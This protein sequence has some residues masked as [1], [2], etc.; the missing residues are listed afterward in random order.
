MNYKKKSIKQIKYYHLVEE[1]GKGASAKVYLA[2]DD[3]KDELVAVKAIPMESLKKDRGMINLQREVKNLNKLK[4][5]NIVR[6]KGF[7]NTKN[8]N[9]V[10]IE[11]CNGGNLFD[12]KKFYEKTTKTTLNEFFIQ[13]II[14]QIADG[15][16][17]MHSKNVVHRDIKLE[18]I[19]IN[20]NK[21]PNYAIK[22]NL[23]K[24]VKLDEVTLNDSFT[25]KIADLGYSKDL[26]SSSLGSTILGTPLNM[27]PDIV[28]NYMAKEGDSKYNTSVDLWSLGTI[29]YQLLTG[30]PPFVGKNYK[31]IFKLIMEGKY[32]LPT[33]LVAS[34]EIITFINGLLQ[35]YPNKRLTWSQIKTH[36]FITKSTDSFTYIQLNSLKESDKK[37]IEMNSKDCDN[38]LWIL[39]KGKGLN[40]NIDK[41]NIQDLKKDQMKQSLS[42]NTVNNDEIKKAIEAEKK[43]IEEEK[44]RLLT[45]KNEAEKLKKEAEDLKKEANLIQEKNEQEKAKLNEEEKKRKELEEKLKKDGVINELKEKEIKKQ[46]DEYTNKIKEV[47]KTKKE[48]DQKLKDAEKLLKNAEK[49]Q[50]EAEN[51]MNNLNKQKEIEENNRK[52]EEEKFKLKQKELLEEKDKFEKEIEKIKDEQ[53][54]KEETYAEE[55]N[56]LNKQIEEMSKVKEDLEKEVDK[57]KEVQ[58]ELQKKEY[59]IKEYQDKLKKITEEKDKEIEK[60]E[61]EKKQ[62][63]M[64]Q[65]K[66]KFNAENLKLNLLEEESKEKNDDKNDFDLDNNN[67]KINDN[68]NSANNKE[69]NIEDEYSDWV[70]YKEEQAESIVNDV[71]YQKDLLD[72]YEIIENYDENDQKIAT[73]KKIE[74]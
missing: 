4:H 65:E 12:Y 48:N 70:F 5:E 61:S 27:S 7:E 54:K 20:F 29:T 24:K 55:K 47:E 60:C 13:K 19:L 32:K 51:Q 33:T 46:I 17:F 63:E 73:S 25:L 2:V 43:K 6:I 68:D 66:V 21:F 8:N 34:I 28:S 26:E 52:M 62:L 53:K 22:G 1:I 57:N 72:E 23:P 71:D 44:Q 74:V 3:R 67:L 58:N 64:L 56:K 16:E 50:K 42:E 38:L 41:I 45:E 11:Y 14:R 36:P 37:E 59:A 31:E 9:Y 39:F 15:L 35:F 69:E 40:M 10:I 30:K 49:M 18:N